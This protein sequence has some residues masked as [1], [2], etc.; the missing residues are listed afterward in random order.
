MN[1]PILLLAAAAMTQPV[2]QSPTPK[3]SNLRPT[4]SV[5]AHATARIMVISGVKFG[6]G[7]SDIPAS[8]S[9][10]SA[11]LT[12]YDGQVRTAELLEFQ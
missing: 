8:A 5:S 1:G 2:A 4:A 9:R 12:D 6:E 10:R 3:A 11:S 7:Y